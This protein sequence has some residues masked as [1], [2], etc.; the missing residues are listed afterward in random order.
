MENKKLVVGNMKMNL[1]ATEI[2]KYLKIIDKKEYNKQVIFCPSNIYLPYFIGNKY[3]V[4][5]QNISEYE[6]GA[7]TGEV[8]ALQVSSM[9]I[10]YVLV[11]HSERREYYKET[12]DL[13]RTKLA[14]ALKSKLKVILCIGETEAERDSLSTYKVLKHQLTVALKGMDNEYYKNIIIAYEPVWSIGTGKVPTNTEIEDTITFIKKMVMDLCNT[15][16]RVLYGGSVNDEN[17]EDLN[18]IPNVDGYLVGGASIKL[19]KFN[20]IIEVVVNQ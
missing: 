17:I 4:G 2:N 14:I 6:S 15:N 5:I 13:V 7:Y 11:G 3:G 16:I 19:D 10:D 1:S 8:S 12:D 18:T 9:K 20:K